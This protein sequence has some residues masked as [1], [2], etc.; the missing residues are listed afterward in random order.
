MVQGVSPPVDFTPMDSS[1]TKG[2]RLPYGNISGLYRNDVTR[3]FYTRYSVNGVR[4]W[5][6]HKTTDEK[7]AKVL[8]GEKLVQV[9]KDRQSGMR[10]SSD[11]STLGAL[12]AELRRIWSEDLTKQD[13]KTARLDSLNRMKAGWECCRLGKWET[14]KARTVT[15]DRLVS[16]RNALIKAVRWKRRGSHKKWCVGYSNPATNYAL[17]VMHQMLDIAYHK[18]AINENPFNEPSLGREE[19]YLPQETR[20][21]VELPTIS[22]MERVFT[23]LENPTKAIEDSSG[24]KLVGRYDDLSA[25]LAAH[26]RR[27]AKETGR[28]ARL[29]AY[30]GMRVSELAGR[31]VKNAETGKLELVPGS[32]A[33]IAD[34][35]GKK[36]HIRGTKTK[37]SDRKIPVSDGLRAVLDEIRS[38]KVAGPLVTIEDIN[39]ALAKACKAVGVKKLS[40]HDLRHYFATICIEGGTDIPTVSRWLGHSDGGALA[41]R[42]YGHLRD[43]HS[44]AAM[45]KVSF[46]APTSRLRLA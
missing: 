20:K 17:R 44:L 45:A 31:K 19:I 43:E 15:Y 26:L 8:H 38:E 40:H 34:D 16:I 36:F 6:S 29:I 2:K 12:E 1:G 30:S 14:T 3:I 42:T 37:T 22:D 23:E 4:N 7:R 10:G 18:R 27:V 13:T 46:V 39:P 25:D 5:H 35:L 9:E 11:F 32:Q 21:K 24:T 28:F 41:M 33:T